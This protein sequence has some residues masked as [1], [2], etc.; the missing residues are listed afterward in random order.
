MI[1][2]RGRMP[3]FVTMYAKVVAKSGLNYLDAAKTR[4]NL[5]RH[6]NDQANNDIA[7]IKSSLLLG[8]K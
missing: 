6:K 1:K 4:L 5:K 3:L 7:N 8:T 2:K